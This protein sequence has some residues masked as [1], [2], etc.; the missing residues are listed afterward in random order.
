MEN[1]AADKK[2]R[3]KGSL[4]L[5]EKGLFSKTCPFPHFPFWKQVRLLGELSGKWTNNPNKY[6][7]KPLRVLAAIQD[8]QTFVKW[9]KKKKETNIL[10][11][12]NTNSPRS[13]L[14]PVRFD[15]LFCSLY[16]PQDIPALSLSEPFQQP[17]IQQLE[18]SGY[19]HMLQHK[20]EQTLISWHLSLPPLQ[21]GESSNSS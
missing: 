17:Q 19:S 4:G 1:R 21:P 5:L 20:M 8:R 13:L 7:W 2:R 14:P 12:T 15:G 11:S 3:R 9:L 18:V 10:L 16:S 6:R